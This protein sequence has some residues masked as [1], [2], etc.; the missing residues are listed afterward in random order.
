[1]GD[2]VVDQQGEE[3]PARVCR[4]GVSWK[5]EPTDRQFDGQTLRSG[6]VLP[7]C[8]TSRTALR[9]M[10]VARKSRERNGFRHLNA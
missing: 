8:I 1:M 7:E 3:E 10:S 2:N 4:I 5:T 6:N 9:L